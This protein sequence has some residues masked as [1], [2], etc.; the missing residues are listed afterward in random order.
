MLPV[1]TVPQCGQQV[2]F[3]ATEI[4]LNNIAFSTAAEIVTFA[5]W[6]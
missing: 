6:I 3:C 5:V 4:M 2:T 1:N